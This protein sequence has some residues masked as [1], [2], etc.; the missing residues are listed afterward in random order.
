MTLGHQN[1]NN[2]EK[3]TVTTMTIGRMTISID[4][5]PCAL[6]VSDTSRTVVRM[7]RME[8]GTLVFVLK[9]Q[10]GVQ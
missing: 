3:S 7:K 10:I 9:R 5:D 4:D 2:E 1:E 8:R 6:P